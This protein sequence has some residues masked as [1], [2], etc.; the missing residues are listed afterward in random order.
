MQKFM[1]PKIA[2]EICLS[3]ESICVSKVT[4]HSY[5]RAIDKQEKT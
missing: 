1:R 3:I 4:V 5:Y 2:D